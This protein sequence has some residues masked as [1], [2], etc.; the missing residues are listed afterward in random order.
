MSGEALPIV[1][2]M[3]DADSYDRLQGQVVFAGCCVPEEPPE[4]RCRQCS[5]EWGTVRLSVGG[6]D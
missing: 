6:Q 3:P 5:V 1:Y 4:L 2:G